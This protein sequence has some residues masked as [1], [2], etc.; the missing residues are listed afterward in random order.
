MNTLDSELR[1]VQRMMYSTINMLRKLRLITKADIQVGSD[2]FQDKFETP[3]G[4]DYL[5]FN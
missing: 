4:Y 1:K 3:C 2:E 5:M